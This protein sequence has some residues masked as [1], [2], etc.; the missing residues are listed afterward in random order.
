[1]K[2]N[3]KNYILNG[4]PIDENI[5]F[6]RNDYTDFVLWCRECFLENFSKDGLHDIY[7]WN[8]IQKTGQS[9]EDFKKE[10]ANHVGRVWTDDSDGLPCHNCTENS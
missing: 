10:V 4:E 6:V 9:F 7:E 8:D 3:V 1:M 5:T 2:D